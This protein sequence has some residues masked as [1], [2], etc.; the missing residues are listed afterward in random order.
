[1]QQAQAHPAPPSARARI[2]GRWAIS[3]WLFIISAAL[4]IA[5][6]LLAR[7]G[8]VLGPFDASTASPFGVAAEVACI[9]LLLVVAD[10]TLFRH[11]AEHPVPVWWVVGLG[12]AAGVMRIGVQAAFSDGRLAHTTTAAAA[13]VGAL[14]VVALGSLVPPVVAYLTATREWYRVERE[15][16]IARAAEAEAERL[17]AVGAL[18]EIALATVQM[19]LDRVRVMMEAREAP[20]G[21]VADALLVAARGGVRPTAHGMMDRPAAAQASV[22]LREVVTEEFH[23]APLPI[24]V[25]AVAFALLIAPR[26]LIARGTVAAVVVPIIA[27]LGILI[28]FPIGRRLIRRSTRLA[29]PITAAA[30]AV[31]AL[32]ILAVTSI[33]VTTNAPVAVFLVATGVL[34]LL[35]VVAGMVATAE[36]LGEEVLTELSRPI[37]EAEIERIAADR[38]RD[39]LLGEIGLH[40]HGTVQSGLIAASYGIQDA[41]A[42]GD[43]EALEGAMAH[44]REVLERGVAGEQSTAGGGDFA[45]LAG[46]WGDLLEVEWRLDPDDAPA[47]AAAVPV[48]REC[49][50]NAVIHGHAGHVV[51]VIRRA[52]DGAEIE[53]VDDG[54]GP[55]GGPAGGG[56]SLLDRATG[57]NWRLDSGPTGGTRVSARVPL[58]P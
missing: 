19:D 51:V 6:A 18:R 49:L 53:V 4:V 41:L 2:G 13:V 17:R 30:C 56:A 25:P 3:W 10:R 58:A 16:L 46:E 22:S 44:A 39:M 5:P 24:L 15:R 1:M 52:G 32:F 31:P 55:Q 42:V 7:T 27:V 26:A 40:L 21:D 37:R 45:T 8:I 57:G 36:E 29:L 28:A 38:A 20:P 50:A 33:G 12:V 9:G 23:R 34:F 14:A 11:R 35:V 48:V 47:V 54:V 43:D